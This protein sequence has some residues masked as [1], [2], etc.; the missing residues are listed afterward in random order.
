MGWSKGNGQ[1]VFRLGQ[2]TPASSKSQ[3]PERPK[4]V[5]GST[6]FSDKTIILADV[7]LNYRDDE[8]FEDFVA[9]NDLGL[10]LAYAIANGIVEASPT[11][12][13]FVNETFQL[14]LSG[15]EVDDMVFESL[16]D[17]L[18]ASFHDGP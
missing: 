4:K 16:D 10:P 5:T 11:A 1:K 15:L 8:N 17:I 13:E 3:V 14:L 9:Y 12:T 7:W 18:E 2:Q 6:S